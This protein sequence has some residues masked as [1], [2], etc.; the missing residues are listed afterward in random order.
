MWR[1]SIAVT[2]S[3]KICYI[4]GQSG[5]WLNPET[6]VL[7]PVCLYKSTRQNYVHVFSETSAFSEVDGLTGQ[8]HIHMGLHED[9]A[10]TAPRFAFGCQGDCQ[11]L[12]ENPSQAHSVLLSSDMHFQTSFVL[13]NKMSTHIW[14]VFYIW[15]H[16]NIWKLLFIDNGMLCK[17]K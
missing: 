8:S 7:Y 11:T 2:Y 10:S 5:F 13:L 1:F 15:K 17:I 3:E 9:D 4:L 6:F 16:V 14:L 12:W